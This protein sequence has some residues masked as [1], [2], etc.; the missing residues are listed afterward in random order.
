MSTESPITEESG[1]GVAPALFRR[2]RGRVDR[3]AARAAHAASGTAGEIDSAGLVV[4]LAL[5]VFAVP[6]GIWLVYSGKVVSGGGLSAFVEAAVGRRAAVVHGWIWAFAYFLYLPYTVTFVVYDLLPP[7][8]PG[9][10]AVPLAHSSSSC[11][12]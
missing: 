5:A 7:V 8:F 4:L 6:L 10:S 9:I 1:A 2:L 3:R 11:R 12:S